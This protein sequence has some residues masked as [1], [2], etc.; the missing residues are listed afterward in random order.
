MLFATVLYVALA[1]A[2]PTKRSTTCQFPSDKGLI[3]ITPKSL[4]AGWAMSPDQSC[5][6]GMY[7]PYACPPG[8]LMA[9]WDQSATSYTY[10]QSQNGGLYC[11]DDGSVSKPFSGKD[12]CVDGA[13][14]VNVDNKATQNVA[15]CQTVLPGGEAMLIPTNVD[16]GQTQA[17]A[18]PDQNYWAS[19]SAHFYVNS[20]GVSPDDGC[21]WGSS[22]KATGNWAPYV[23]GTNMDSNG[24]TYVKIGWN[25]KYLESFSDLPSFGIRVACDS[26]DC[27][28][29]SCE[30][31][32]S[33]TGL[34]GVKSDNAAKGD[35][36]SYCVVTALNKASA[37]IEV[38]SV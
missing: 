2:A 1:A 36:A 35:G 4:N 27:S 13:G 32:P 3:A 24:N 16:G 25:P 6:A 9:Q 31:D 10:P 34:N 37:R 17:L 29:L 19:T 22:S 15:F 14:T 30:I 7:C 8:Q 33:S 18:V 26:G 20:L 12:Y 28:G 5:T 23:A 21:V 38:F 11:N